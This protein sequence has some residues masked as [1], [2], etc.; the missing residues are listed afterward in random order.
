MKPKAHISSSPSSDFIGN[1]KVI[2]PIRH[3]LQY[4][5]LIKRYAYFKV[6]AG[7]II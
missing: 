1:I 6:S 4:Y 3:E 2:S 7:N 5:R